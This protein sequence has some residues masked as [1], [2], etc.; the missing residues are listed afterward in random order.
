MIRR[1]SGPSCDA[2]A[3]F[4]QERMKDERK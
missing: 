3:R 4:N 2:K 1:F